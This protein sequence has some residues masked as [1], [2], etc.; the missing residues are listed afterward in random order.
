MVVLAD[1]GTFKVRPKAF[2]RVG[3]NSAVNVPLAVVDA[4]PRHDAVNGAISLVLVGDKDSLGDI[5]GA[6][7]KAHD[8]LPAQVMGDTGHDFAAPLDRAYNS[9]LFRATPTLGRVVIIIALIT[10]GL[11]THVSFVHFNDIL[12]QLAFLARHGSTDP[13]L[14]VPSGLMGRLDIAP[15]LIAGQAFLRVDH[16]GDRQEP[17]LQR[18]LS[19]LENGALQDIEALA[20]IMAVPAAYTLV[21]FLTPNA[22]AGTVRTVRIVAPVKGLKMVDAGLLIGEFLEDGNQVHNAGSFHLSI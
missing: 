2:N 3:V 4:E 22:D 13:L 9:G 21:L 17:L 1:P 19:A 8:A 6:L 14:H 12:E 20:A 5:N 10:P 16:E 18:D 7:D 11:P 15:Q